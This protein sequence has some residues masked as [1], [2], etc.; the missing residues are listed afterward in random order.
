MHDARMHEHEHGP[1][2]RG[3]GRGR[4]R[5]DM[6]GGPGPGWGG[7]RR[8]MR[9]GDTRRAI[10]LALL[11]GP[12][13]GYEVMRRLEER[14]GGLWRPSPGSVYPTL[15]MLE[16]EGLVTSTTRDASRSFE[17]TDS[18]REAATAGSAEP[19]GRAPWDRGDENDD[20][21]RALRE[22]MGQA[23][24]AAKQVAHTGK[25]DQLD[26]GIEIVQRARKELYQI[27]AED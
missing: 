6:L 3:R 23:F 12:A 9:R 25:P 17:L 13:N 4:M 18:G 5:P 7:S 8:R 11:D 1:M 14:S 22:A 10:L 26:R 20:R 21:V 24:Q 19:G 2:G 15:Q 16:D 27:L